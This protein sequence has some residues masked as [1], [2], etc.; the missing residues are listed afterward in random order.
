MILIYFY[1]LV[2]YVSKYFLVYL[3][4]LNNIDQYGKLTIPSQ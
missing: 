3:K 1:E 4:F 2:L